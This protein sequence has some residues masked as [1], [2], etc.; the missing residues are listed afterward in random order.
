MTNYIG[1]DLPSKVSDLVNIT[2]EAMIAEIVD[3][4]L[5]KKSSKVEVV[6]SGKDWDN[7]S[8]ITYDNSPIGF[9]SEEELDTAFRMGGKKER[10][11]DDIGSFHM[12]AKSSTLSKFKDIAIFTKING[13]FYHRRM[14]KTEIQ[15]TYKPE[16]NPTYPIAEE[17]Q[18]KIENDD[19]TTAFVCYNPLSRL[20]NKTDAQ[21]KKSSID[22]FSAAVSLFLGIIYQRILNENPKLSIIVNDEEVSSVDPF[23]RNFTPQAI[24][25]RLDLQPGQEGYV[26][27]AMVRNI[28]QCAL[29]WGTIATEKVSFDIEYEGESYPIKVQGFVIPYGEVRK[30]LEKYDLVSNEFIE[31]PNKAGTDTLKAQYLQGFFFY[32]E[33]R[34]IGFGS[35]GKNSNDG[36]YLYGGG[37]PSTWLGVRL[38]VDFPK[39]LDKFMRLSPAKDTVNPQELFFD[40]IQKAWDQRIK[41]PLLRAKLGDGK[42]P[43][44]DYNNPSKSVVGAAASSNFQSK[45]W[46]DNCPHCEGFHPKGT[47]CSYAPCSV[48]GSVGGKCYPKCTH[49]CKYCKTKGHLEK[50]CPLNCKHCGKEGGHASGE[51]CPELCQICQKENCTCDCQECGKSK[52]ECT[53]EKTCKDCNKL[54]SLCEC[55]Q[56]DSEIEPYVEDKM[57]QLILYRKNRNENISYIKEAMEF[58]GI[59]KEEL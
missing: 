36:W 40:K 29:P 56:E 12:G 25:E 13:E 5:D 50:D 45:L 41:E 58:L 2:I 34:C 26:H 57:I 52:H 10:D 6:I 49:Q 9:S 35:T 15:E 48:C 44:W 8:I 23:W 42:R 19:Y 59:K 28:L 22:G 24:S 43:F 39:E 38:M 55:G 17:V 32:R 20:L 47:I 33:G 37:R 21:I 46:D 54:Q 1:E 27:D 14:N 18:K 3:N 31:R 30:K 4:S 51:K 11:D 16:K 7:F 53:C